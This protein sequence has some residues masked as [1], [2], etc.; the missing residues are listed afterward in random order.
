MISKEKIKFIRSLHRKKFREIHRQFIIEGPKLIKEAIEHAPEHIVNI[1]S[2]KDL[3]LPSLINVEGISEK[4]LSQVS[5]LQH[6]QECIAICNFLQKQEKETDFY[7]ALDTVQDPGNLGTILRLA[8]WFG[9][10]KIIVSK[11]TADIYNPKVIQATMGTIFHVSVEYTNLKDFIE[12]SSLPVYGALMEGEN[13]YT[14]EK[15]KL[16]GILLMGNEGSG[17]HSDLLP[18]ITNPITIPK[19]GKGESLN[20]AMATGILLSEFIG[21]KTEPTV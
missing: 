21:R 5:A 8:A 15:E 17:I 19:F 6:P 14:K 12:N 16:K 13:I 2:T 10:E 7:L 20:V 3:E 4:E 9:V 11:E 1:Y 18:L